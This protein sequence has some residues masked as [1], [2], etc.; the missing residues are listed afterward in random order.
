MNTSTV[1]L[2]YKRL[3]TDAEF[4]ERVAA[5]PQMYYAGRFL[6]DYSGQHLDDFVWDVTRMQRRI[7]EIF[8]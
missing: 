2:A 7:V 5:H 6:K 3:E 4:Q 1:K 8:P